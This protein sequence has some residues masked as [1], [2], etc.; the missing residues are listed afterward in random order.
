MAHLRFAG[1]AALLGLL[2]AC[3]EPSSNTRFPAPTLSGQAAPAA[4]AP[5]AASL[6]PTPAATPAPNAPHGSERAFVVF[7]EEWSAALSE[8]AQAGLNRVA[9]MALAEPRVGVLV[10]GY[11]GPRGSEEANALLARLRARQVADALIEKGI[12]SSRIRILSR[13]PT[14]GFESLESRRVEVRIDD[15]RR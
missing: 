3:A 6:A 5:P 10:L 9:Q 15:G 11:T 2:V 8:P 14:P 1:T 4:A 12:A 13:G 7:F